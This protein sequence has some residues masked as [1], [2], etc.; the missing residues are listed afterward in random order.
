MVALKGDLL[1][2]IYNFFKGMKMLVRVRHICFLIDIS[3][4]KDLSER[5]ITFISRLWSAS[6]WRVMAKRDSG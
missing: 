1:T 2:S 4:L 3:Y 5:E 6:M